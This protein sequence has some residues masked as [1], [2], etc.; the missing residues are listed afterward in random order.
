MTAALLA[1]LGFAV[2]VILHELGHFTAAKM[3]GMRVERFALFFPPLVAKK[4]WGE[5]EYAIGAIPLGGYVKITGM[6]P[7]EELSPELKARS[8][9]GSPVWKRIFVIAAGPFVNLVVAFLLL[10]GIF[11]YQGKPVP[12]VAVGSV[13]ANG[14]AAQILQPDDRILSITAPAAGGMAALKAQGDVPNMT[15]KQMDAALVQMQK[16]ITSGGCGVKRGDRCP[17]S[18]QPVDVTLV[19]DGQTKTVQITPAY[20]PTKGIERYRLGIGFGG[21][22]A[23]VGALESARLSLDG[24]WNVTRSTGETLVKI[25][26]PEVREQMSSVVGGYE[27]TRQSFEVDTVQ[28][29]TILALI[30]LSLAIINLL[31]ILPLDGGHIFWA[32]IEKLRGG[33][34]VPTRILERSTVIGFAL[35][36]VLFFIGLSNDVGHILDGSGFGVK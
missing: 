15:Q 8:Y 7:E 26:K 19:R 3:V 12:A 23:S 4:K 35:V 16:V 36:M 32:I 31:P 2:L 18:A 33:K 17:G 11:L 22:Y 10:L 30:S 14:A 21:A 24:M 20:D 27:A 29:L 9:S 34:P 28:A 1:F 13:D 25:Y 5:T 6:N